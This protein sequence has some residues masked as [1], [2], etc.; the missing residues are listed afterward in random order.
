MAKYELTKE[1]YKTAS[2]KTL[3]RVRAVQNIYQK[4]RT[5]AKGTIGGYVESPANL[6]QEGNAWLAENAM[7]MGKTIIEGDAW[8]GGNAVISGSSVITDSADVWG[9]SFVE[10]STVGGH[11][12]VKDRA[13]VQ[14]SQLTGD[15]IVQDSGDVIKSSLD[16]TVNV[17]EKARIF[18]STAKGKDVVLMGKT[19]I[20]LSN[21]G[22]VSTF[23]DPE[24]LVIG[25]DTSLIRTR[26]HGNDIVIS[27]NAKLGKEV[28]LLGENIRISDYAEISGKVEI[29]SY[30][31]LSELA[32]IENKGVE[33]LKLYNMTIDGD[34]V[35]QKK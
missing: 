16:G 23:D 5:V 25:G 9:N 26:I 29:L 14:D 34:A 30:V 15:V 1:T 7:A 3:Y 2:G 20:D 22:G 17:M 11:C 19:N 4:G 6:S 28:I 8:V 18:G 27:G 35:L 31:I 12:K 10:S 13:N 24:K 21:I 33:P 32:V